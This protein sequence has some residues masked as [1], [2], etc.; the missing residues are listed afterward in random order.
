MTSAPALAGAALVGVVAG[1]GVAVVWQRTQRSRMHPRS[2]WLRLTR[3]TRTRIEADSPGSKFPTE[4]PELPTIGGSPALALTS[5]TM[6]RINESIPVI[7][8]AEAASIFYG[9]L[10]SISPELKPLFGSTSQQERM[11]MGMLKWVG[12]AISDTPTLA[13]GLRALGE[14]HVKY[15][16][17]LQHFSAVKSSFMQMVS[18]VDQQALNDRENAESSDDA[19]SSDDDR[20]SPLQ[21][22]RFGAQPVDRHQRLLDVSAAW[23]A[24]LY[25]FIGEMSPMMLMQDTLESLHNALANDLAAPAG[26]TCVA[27]TAAQGASLLMMAA[28]L[29]RGPYPGSPE[30]ATVD[31]AHAELAGARKCL[32]RLAG[33]DMSAYCRVMAA[34]RQPKLGAAEERLNAVE[35]SYEQAA[36]VSMQVAEWAVHSLKVAR[37][38]LPIASAS[39]CGDAGAGSLLLVAASKAA[40]QAVLQHTS[41]KVVLDSFAWWGEAYEQ[42]VSELS[43]EL[44]SLEEELHA[45]STT[46]VCGFRD[47]E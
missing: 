35:L 36:S 1:F 39:G 6:R 9:E 16:A 43:A 12:G 30:R 18:I 3:R 46:V 19:F 17:H 23:E 20:D 42:R 15:R 44:D 37:V 14:R 41:S 2:I 32:E 4:R 11:L 40:M 33:L 8:S 34:L 29:T 47:G 13:E 38:L 45:L 21:R 26:G 24:L 31:R 5:D 10:F 25:V 28:A 22:R 7:G 27:L